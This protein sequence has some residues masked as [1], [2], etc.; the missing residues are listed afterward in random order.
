MRANQIARIT[1]DFKMGIIKQ[2][3][4]I[5]I[6]IILKDN[7]NVLWLKVLKKEHKLSAVDLQPSTD[8]NMECK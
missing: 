1:S 2:I 6:I 8:K 5:T 3:I 7:K 4:I